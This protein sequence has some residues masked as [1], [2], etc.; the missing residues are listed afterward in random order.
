M[1]IEKAI[2][3]IRRALEVHNRD[4]FAIVDD[5]ALYKALD[6]LTAVQTAKADLE[7]K[8]RDDEHADKRG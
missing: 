7:A 6:I 8:R 4:G 5:E 1:T 3:H 2:I